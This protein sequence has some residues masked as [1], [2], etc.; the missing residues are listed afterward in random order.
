MCIALWT[1]YVFVS[2]SDRLIGKTSAQK[3]FIKTQESFLAFISYWFISTL[4]LKH[5]E[6]LYKQIDVNR[7]NNFVV[8]IK[9]GQLLEAPEVF[10]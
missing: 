5:M 2:Q 4:I 3:S 9:H 7:L 10:S 1:K 6:F 8:E